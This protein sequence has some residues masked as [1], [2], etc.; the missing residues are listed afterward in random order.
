MDSGALVLPDLGLGLG[1]GE[2]GVRR[3]GEWLVGQ[4][5]PVLYSNV[6]GQ[7]ELGFVLMGL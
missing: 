3:H 2:R 4:V 7:R 1:S 6:G 5:L